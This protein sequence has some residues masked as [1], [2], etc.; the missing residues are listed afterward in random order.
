M[1][2][3]DGPRG[4]R[5][6]TRTV[7]AAKNKAKLSRNFHFAFLR[8]TPKYVQKGPQEKFLPWRPIF[9][10]KIRQKPAYDRGCSELRQIVTWKCHKGRGEDGATMTRYRTPSE[11]F[12][13]FFFFWQVWIQS[14]TW[15]HIRVLKATC[16]WCIAGASLAPSWHKLAG[17]P[18]WRFETQTSDTP[19]RN[20]DATGRA[21]GDALL[22]TAVGRGLKQ[23]DLMCKGKSLLRNMSVQLGLLCSQG[24][25]MRKRETREKLLKRGLRKFHHPT[26]WFFMRKTRGNSR[27]I[28]IFASFF[29]S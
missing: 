22:E 20:G 17:N 11:D 14:E 2:F 28:L 12:C 8:D 16:K 7:F 18:E 27:E 13:C 9:G 10:E 6:E 24:G 19:Q 1:E 4:Y 26:G 5:G 15:E 21:Q 3:C 25:E 23:R 29:V